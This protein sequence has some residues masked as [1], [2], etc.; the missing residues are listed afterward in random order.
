MTGAP[1]VQ[2]D[3][4]VIGGSY[5]G[6]SAATYIARGRHSVCVVDAGA[7]RNRFSDAAHGFFG[8][9]GAKPAEM[10]QTARRQLELYPTVSFID[11]LATDARR[12]GAAF[13]VT[14]ASGRLLSA[15]KIVLA[16]GVSDMLPDLP[17]L[18]ELWGKSVLHCPY[19]HGYEFG[20][21]QLGVLG[22][23]QMSA[24]QAQLIANWGPTTFFLNGR[25]N[26]DDPTRAKLQASGVQIEATPVV[27]L[28][29]AAPEIKAMRL[30][31]ERRI[32]LDALFIM[33]P[34]RPGSPIAERLGCAFDEEPLGPLVRVDP[35][36]MTSVPGAYAAGDVTRA[37]SSATFAAAD[38]VAAGS[39]I[40][41]ALIFGAPST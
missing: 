31:D 39:A 12:T 13:A 18:P 23:S 36:M 8:Q 17:G 9:D 35:T 16:I 4:I 25:V 1:H 7:P 37:Y 11:E 33:A 5:A 27:E 29:G 21:R 32:T 20:G 3:A 14:L 30:A 6:L 10:I 34:I 24:H 22:M 28:E 26:L 40:S 41:Q 38:G 2:F 19:C 15:T